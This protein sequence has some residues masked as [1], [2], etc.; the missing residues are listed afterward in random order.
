MSKYE[1]REI[2]ESEVMHIHC[3]YCGWCVNCQVEGISC[4]LDGIKGLC[5]S[6]AKT[7]LDLE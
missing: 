3:Q 4:V 7:Q 6:C 5:A 1:T 2:A